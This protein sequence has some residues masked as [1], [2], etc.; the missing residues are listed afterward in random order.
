M[1]SKCCWAFHQQQTFASY[2]DSTLQPT[3]DTLSQ[4]IPI[5]KKQVSPSA[6]G[7]TYIVKCESH[8]PKFVEKYAHQ[9]PTLLSKHIT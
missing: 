1:L 2:L 3:E 6:S 9:H 5:S 4:Q 8:F 7:H